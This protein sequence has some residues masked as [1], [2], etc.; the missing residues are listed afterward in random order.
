[1]GRVVRKRAVR[2]VERPAA[3]E[4]YWSRIV[5]TDD[6]RASIG[7]NGWTYIGPQ[8][9]GALTLEAGVFEMP[10]GTGKATTQLHSHADE[11]FGYILAGRGWIAV[12]DEM[13]AFAAG[14]FVFVPAHARHGWLN[15][16][17]ETVRVLFYRRTKPKVGGRPLDVR[18]YDVE[19]TTA[20]APS[21]ASS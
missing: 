9:C 16:G 4:R 13:H 20:G 3:V 21:H 15:D 10:P 8:T 11:E 18:E 5:V 19:D 1:M 14:D 7:A 17:A 12:E 2:L 6:E